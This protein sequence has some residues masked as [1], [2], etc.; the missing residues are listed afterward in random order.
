M[1]FGVS[2]LGLRVYGVGLRVS[3]FR[4]SRFRVFAV[5][6]HQSLRF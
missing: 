6:R 1:G 5:G 3:D 4:I 2:S